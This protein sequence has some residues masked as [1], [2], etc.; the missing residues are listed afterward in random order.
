MGVV[1]TRAGCPMRP[2][3][4]AGGVI[5]AL[6]RRQR[7]PPGYTAGS[8]QH[9][10][11]SAT[12]PPGPGDQLGHYRLVRLLGSGGMGEVFLAQD[13]LLEREVAIKIVSTSH[14]DDPAIARRLLQDL[15]QRFPEHALAPELQSALAAVAPA[16]P[17]RPPG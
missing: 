14:I 5:C 7:N 1:R 3:V 2:G 9:S 16:A 17:P 15:L 10:C 11:D 13:L 8:V 4:G 12:M 6:G